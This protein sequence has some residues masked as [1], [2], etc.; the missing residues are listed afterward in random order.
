[1]SE[2]AQETLERQHHLAEHP[3]D[4]N[5]KRAALVIGVLAA[6]LAVC[7]M[8][9]RSAQV[10]YLAHYISASNDYAF[11]QSRQ[12]RALVLTQ[13]S[14]IMR[15]LP[16]T[17]Q[18]EKAAADAVAEAARLTE[19]SDRGNGGKQI[20]ARA[21]SETAARDK[22]LHR[23]EWFELITS[24]IQIGIVLGSVAVITRLPLMLWLGAGLGIVSAGLAIAVALDVL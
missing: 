10:G 7:E 9:E 2:L 23:Y 1:M 5:G 24:A 4:G 16:P 3:N 13:T 22:S 20:L 11:Y 12:N 8:A 21:A 17:P 14:E 6:T 15:A 19:D 18:T